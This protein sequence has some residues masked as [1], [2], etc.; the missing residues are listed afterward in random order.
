MKKNIFLGFILI[1]AIPIFAADG[2]ENAGIAP[3]Q[4]HVGLRGWFGDLFNTRF[5]KHQIV[6]TAAGIGAVFSLGYLSGLFDGSEKSLKFLAAGGGIAGYRY[7]RSQY[8]SQNFEMGRL[9]G[10]LEAVTDERD[11]L[12][13]VTNG[14]RFAI[15]R[16]EATTGLHALVSI[17]AYYNQ[18]ETNVIL[19]GNVNSEPARQQV[20]SIERQQAGYRV[21]AAHL[22]RQR[23]LPENSPIRGTLPQGL[24]LAIQANNNGAGILQ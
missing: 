4:Q 8:E 7:G 6:H 22:M 2:G 23:N 24:R 14:F 9:E 5:I 1:S 10:A 18:N 17:G 21:L 12:R 15:D 19:L 11:N 16:M 13:E 20:A 3:A